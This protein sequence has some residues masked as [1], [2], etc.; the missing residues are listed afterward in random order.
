MPEPTSVKEAYETI[1]DALAFLQRAGE[2]PQPGVFEIVI[3]GES[4]DIIHNEREN[5]FELTQIQN[6]RE[7]V[8]GQT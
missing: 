8:S 1:A 2:H 3:M 4:Y 7:E 6:H 5:R